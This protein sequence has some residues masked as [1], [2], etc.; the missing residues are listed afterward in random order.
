MQIAVKPWGEMSVREIQNLKEKKC[1]HCDYFSKNNSGGLP[2]GTCDYILINDRMRGC[3]PTECVM[4]GIFKR[5][6]GAKR[7]A[8]LRI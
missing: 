3:L 4:K 7:R 8:A 2:Y 1:K 6:T 5:R